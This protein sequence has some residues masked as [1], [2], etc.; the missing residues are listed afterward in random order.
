M[1]LS[2]QHLF[3]EFGPPLDSKDIGSLGLGANVAIAPVTLGLNQFG[4]TAF[5]FRLCP[6]LLGAFSSKGA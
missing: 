1:R 6:H 4:T 3:Y 5:A 2:Q